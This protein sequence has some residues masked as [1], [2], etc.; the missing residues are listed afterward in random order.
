[1]AP[2]LNKVTKFL[3]SPQGRK[4]AQQATRMA[5][6]PATRKKVD[7]AV[8]GVRKRF[9]KPSGGPTG[10]TGTAGTTGTTGTTGTDRTS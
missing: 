7:D 3:S 5:K 6:D 4:L 8:S 9:A 10:G 1:V 2:M